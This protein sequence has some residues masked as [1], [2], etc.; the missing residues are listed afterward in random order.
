MTPQAKN[1]HILNE[2]AKA[3]EPSHGSSD[4]YQKM[5]ALDETNDLVS[6]LRQNLES[7]FQ[8]EKRLGFMI[9]EVKSTIKRKL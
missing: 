5:K 3:F 2:L 6:M 4:L 1:K 7:V 9:S 8:S